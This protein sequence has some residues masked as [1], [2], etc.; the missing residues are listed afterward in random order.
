M[1]RSAQTRRRYT[2]IIGISKLFEIRVLVNS[3]YVKSI[4]TIKRNPNEV[5][6]P[7]A[8]LAPISSNKIDLE[9]IYR[10]G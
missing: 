5:M 1:N 8:G 2:T 3:K 10:L 7:S 6:M 9:L 4:G